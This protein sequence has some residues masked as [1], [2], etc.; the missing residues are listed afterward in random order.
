MTATAPGGPPDWSPMSPRVDRRSLLTVGA[1]SVLAWACSGQEDTGLEPIF[2]S[3]TDTDPPGQD[4][5]Q[6]EASAATLAMIGDSI[7]FMSTEALQATLSTTGLEVLA[8]DAQ[9]GRRITV[10]NGGRPHSGV[11][12]AAFIAN[13]D[14]PDVWVIALGTNDIGQYADAAEFA[15]HVKSLLDVLPSAAPLV[16]VDTWDGGR[17]DETRLVNDTLRVMAGTRDDVVIV[18]WSSHGDDDGVVSGDRVHPTEAGTLVF[19]QVVA[20]GVGALLASL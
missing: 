3:A 8:I 4:G 11:D 19:A 2:R 13:S 18:D 1:A 15:T 12:I 7:T 20:E 6:T 16:W 17:P 14:P 10:G 5:E 9:V